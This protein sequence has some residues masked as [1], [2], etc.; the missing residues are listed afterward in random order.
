MQVDLS[1][2]IGKFKAMHG[3]NFA[4]RQNTA[5]LWEHDRD[6]Y[7]KLNIQAVRLHDAPLVN[8]GKHLVDVSQIFINFDADPA[9]S[10]NYFFDQTDDYIRTCVDMGLEVVYRLGESIDH[11]PKRYFA[12]PPKDF[13]KWAEICC[14]IAEHYTKGWAN[15]YTWPINYWC[16][17]CEP[18]EWKLWSGTPE[19]YNRLYE[20]T[21]KKFAERLPEL[22]LGGPAW[23]GCM[24][25]PIENFLK[26]CR[27]R[28]LKLDFI[29]WNQYQALPRLQIGQAAQVKELA[30][31]YGYGDAELM[32]GEWHYFNRR[33]CELKNPDTREDVDD[34]VYGMNGFSAA[35][36]TALCLAGF[37]DTPLDKEFFYTGNSGP[38]G[39]C[40]LNNNP[41]KTAWALEAY[42]KVVSCPERVFAETGPTIS[43]AMLQ[44]GASQAGDVT[45]I[46]GKNGKRSYIMVAAY[47][48]IATSFS[49]ELKG[50]SDFDVNIVVTDKEHNR[51][52]AVFVRHGNVLE[53]EKPSSSA[54]Y[55]I[56]INEK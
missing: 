49:L 16:V 31:K 18:N 43:E 28:E 32:L 5:L 55:L 7:Q 50:I 48:W 9:D 47:M 54:V 25:V 46:A 45:I 38:F 51:D 20:A 6:L 34:P 30:V 19:D 52:N 37:Q 35:G 24:L 27:E 15:G 40:D 42:G 3:V 33:W 2:T 53:I 13:D 23:G 1:N 56:E 12:H 44:H 14:R 29:T 22:K 11:S 21:A 26:F 17:W 41:K 8:P 4:P 39:I 36:Y 10:A